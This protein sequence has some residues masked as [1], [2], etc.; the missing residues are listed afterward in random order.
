MVHRFGLSCMCWVESL[1]EQCSRMFIIEQNGLDAI[2][3]LLQ[4]VLNDE[5]HTCDGQI[6]DTVLCLWVDVAF[7]GGLCGTNGGS[8]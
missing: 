3:G 6:Y 1:E 7:E 8:G 2:L 5:H 4:M